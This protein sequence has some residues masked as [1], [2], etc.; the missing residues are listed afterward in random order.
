MRKTFA[1]AFIILI[2]ISALE[3]RITKELARQIYDASPN[4]MISC[5]VVMKTRYPYGEM[6]S[7]SV[8]SRIRIYRNIAW[9]S[10]QP[11]I[12]WL[13]ERPADVKVRMQ[14]WVLNGFHLKARPSVILEISKRPEVGTIFH[15][16]TVKIIAF[17]S[18]TYR[19]L[20][21][22]VEWGVLKIEADKCWEDG[23][24]GEGVIIGIVDTGVDYLH[25]A[26]EGKW[27]GHWY[28]ADGLPP[29]NTPYD[30]NKHGTHCMGTILGG[31]GFGSFPNDIGVAP[32]AKYAA[33]K[34]LN[35]GGSGSSNQLIECL[36][37]M[38]DLKDSVDIKAVSNSWA[39]SSGG[40]QYY[41]DIFTT[42]MSIGILPIVAN[43]NNGSQG[44]GSVTSPGDYPHVIGVGATDIDDNIADFSSLGP[45]TEES[46]YNDQTLWFRDDWNYIKPNISAPGENIN[47]STPNGEYGQLNG[48]S[49]ATPH[50]CGAVALLFQKNVNL[51]PEMV[52][53]LL[54]DNVDKPSAGGSYPNNT[55]GWGRLNV[56]K[57][58]QATPTMN[59]PWVYVTQKE[60]DEIDPGETVELVVTV[61]NLG[62]ADGGKTTA[63]LITF[64][65]YITLQNTS[66]AYGDLTP[67]QSASNSSSPFKITAHEVTSQGHI[68]TLGIILHAEGE[69]DTLD[70]DDTVTFAFTIGTPPAPM[71]VFEEDF[72]YEGGVDSFSII[73]NTSGNWNRVDAA[74]QSPSHSAFSGAIVDG[75][76][77]C[78]MNNTIDLS[79]FK[80]V[81]FSLWTQYNLDNAFWC[82]AM[83]EISP[84]G[85]NEWN[86][87]WRSPRFSSVDSIS[88]TKQVNDIS[89]YL[90][91]QVKFRFNLESNGTF[92]DYNDWYIDDL[93]VLVDADNEPPY[94][95]NTTLWHSTSETGPFDVQSTVIDISGVN[96]ANL[97]YQVDS[98]SWNKLEMSPEGADVYK[99]AIPAQNG[100]GIINYYLEATDSWFL[101]TA[102]TGTFPIGADQSSGYH[103]FWYGSTGIIDGQHMVKFS[104]CNS[105][106]NGQVNIS[107][108]LPNQMKIKLSIFDVMGRK[109]AS[110]L[111]K[112]VGK[113]KHSILWNRKDHTKGRIATGLYFLKIEANSVKTANAAKSYKRIERILL[114]K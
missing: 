85:G 89:P 101:T 108:Y 48:T 90:S 44:A 70:F 69:H 22:E 114:L 95:T 111:N 11:L 2:L 58:L 27:S 77:F 109:V 56:W 64:D 96:D 93:Q 57:S 30:D 98:G 105:Q 35:S 38:A 12:N 15:D 92:Q 53:N 51:T 21:K 67:K 16:G 65:N 5:I 54:L 14:F 55:F 82:E 112:K 33:A 86:A 32:G 17:P 107:F 34:G 68:A 103:S 66:Y 39:T 113:G 102:N 49:M 19:P 13:S 3:A 81:Y 75:R 4:D 71:I 36:Q 1:S 41:W 24:T 50:V 29:S 20:S 59:Q 43:G 88:W 25:P 78:T 76:A 104:I 26:L 62:G 40:Q 73:W 10:Q 72:E 47:S 31:D 99:A 87:T 74:S 23:Y 18:K 45:T 84:D 91:D 46:P 7:E 6:R 63:E 80:K 100:T 60:M 106:V 9:E 110:I 97:Y 79:Q 52:Y 94:F 37:F 83:V 42:L 61:K 8:K 28:V